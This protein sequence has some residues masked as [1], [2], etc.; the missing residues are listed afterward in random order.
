MKVE[1]E[2]EGHLNWNSRKPGCP[3]LLPRG[4]VA[5]VG[6]SP[7]EPRTRRQL[8]CVQGLGA[9]CCPSA[10]PGSLSPSSTLFL[11]VISHARAWL[12][13]KGL[14]VGLWPDWS[15]EAG[16]SRFLPQ[17]TS[18][19]AWPCTGTVAQGRVTKQTSGPELGK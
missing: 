10:G 7:A 8:H 13:Q 19:S 9:A 17:E 2:A 5:L 15:S 6:C 12:S 1:W 14:V 3:P 4:A 11:V 16:L 18:K